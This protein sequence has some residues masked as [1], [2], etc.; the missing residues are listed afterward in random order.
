M[1]LRLIKPAEALLFS[2]GA[3]T[4]LAIKRLVGDTRPDGSDCFSGH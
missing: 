3:D 4:I 2:T 1:G